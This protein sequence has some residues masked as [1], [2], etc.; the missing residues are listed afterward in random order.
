MY[1]KL[2]DRVAD[3]LEDSLRYSEKTWESGGHLGTS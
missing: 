1:T 2:V 3:M